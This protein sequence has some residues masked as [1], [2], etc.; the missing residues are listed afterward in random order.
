MTTVLGRIDFLPESYFMVSPRFCF[1]QGGANP[2]LLITNLPSCVI[3]KMEIQ[4][5]FSNI[6]DPEETL[7]SVLMSEDEVALFS[8]IQ[9]EFGFKSK[10]LGY[11]APGSYQ[12]KEAAKYAYDDDEYKKKRGGYALKGLLTP[13]TATYMKK[14]A[15]KMAEEGKSKEEIRKYLENPSKKR[16]AAGVG[17]AMTGSGL[18]IGGAVATGVGIYDKI[19]GHRAKTGKK[20]K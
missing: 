19:T 5:V 2:Y 9:K 7:Y 11:V 14:K 20:E 15:Q 4:K 10:A 1:I 6:E 3:Y 8:E 16:I 18:G 13:G 17:E 12:A